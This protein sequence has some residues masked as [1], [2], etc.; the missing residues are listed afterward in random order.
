MFSLYAAGR[1]AE[2]CTD[3]HQADAALSEATWPDTVWI[4][5]LKPVRDEELKLEARLGVQLPTREDMAEIEASSRLYLEDGAAFMTAQIVFFGGQAHL[6]SG[7]VTFVLAGQ[8]LVTI[9]YVEPASF[10]IFRDHTLK[11]PLLCADGPATF[12]NLLDVIIDRTA[13]LIEKTQGGIDELSRSIFTSR[14]HK[15]L[16]DVLIQLGNAQNDIVK[17]RDSLVTFARLTAFAA[18]L[19]PAL[20]RGKATGSQDFQDRLHTMSQDV[21]SLSDHATYVSG[22]IAFLL[23]AA[24]GLIN[25]E[26]NSVMKVISV[27]SVVFLPLTLIASIY[28]MNFDHMPFLHNPD[29]FWASLIIMFAIAVALVWWFRAKR[30]V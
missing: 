7:P 1:D 26:Q 2:I 22:N 25:V 3:P 12:L 19:D 20:T 23:D 8:R 30:W 4:D 17:I 21:A 15:R 11:Q 13:D 14:R 16:E 9:R 28:G 24:L 18:G 10:T 29:A 27:T 5:L 6:Q